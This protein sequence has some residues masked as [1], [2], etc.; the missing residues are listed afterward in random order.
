MSSTSTTR[1]TSSMLAL[2][3]M[4][5]LAAPGKAS[6]KDTLDAADVSFVKTE[7]A[8]GTADLKLAVLGVQKADR[9]DI[10]NFAE[11]LVTDH[12]NA[13]SQLSA[14]A[15]EK[16]VDVSAE[17]D[18]KRAAAMQKLEKASAANFDKEFLADLI[19]VH[20]KCVSSFEATAKR[21]KNADV[22]QWAARMLPT[23]KAHLAKARE[24]AAD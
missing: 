1:L 20:A 22:K 19:S 8:A 6:P 9:P 17:I 16:G 14:L 2:C 7:S 4:L 3:G 24:L 5:L 21:S 11:M 13:N 10:K 18:P 15:V 12:T 23:L